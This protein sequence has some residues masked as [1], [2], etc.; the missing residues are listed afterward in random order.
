MI[1]KEAAASKPGLP[2][3]PG[4]TFDDILDW[5]YDEDGVPYGKKGPKSFDENLYRVFWSRTPERSATGY[6]DFG[7][8]RP[9]PAKIPFEQTID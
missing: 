7:W 1:E 9:A 6:I 5:Q 3:V 8:M 4:K 2:G